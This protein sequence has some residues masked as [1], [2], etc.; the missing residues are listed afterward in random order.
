V[1]IRNRQLCESREASQSLLGSIVGIAAIRA[2]RQTSSTLGS[3][4]V[5]HSVLVFCLGEAS[6]EQ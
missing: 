2:G 4:T 1:R 3:A 5:E 6:I